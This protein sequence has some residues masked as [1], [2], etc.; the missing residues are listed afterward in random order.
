MKWEY[1]ILYF[2]PKYLGEY[3]KLGAEGWEAI[4]I[5]PAGFL[6]MKKAR[7]PQVASRKSRLAKT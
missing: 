7:T 5:S 1:N 6:L 3:N 2:A 4:A